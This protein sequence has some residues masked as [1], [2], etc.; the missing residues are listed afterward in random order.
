MRGWCGRL[1]WWGRRGQDSGAKERTN[2]WANSLVFILLVVIHVGFGI[3]FISRLQ[4]HFT[5]VRR[6]THDS[7]VVVLTLPTCATPYAK[8][9]RRFYATR[10]TVC[11]FWKNFDEYFW[12][13]YCFEV[14]PC[15]SPIRFVL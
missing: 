8:R 3:P 12:H 13:F 11:A 4:Q 14:T 1:H 15:V 9:P 2:R 10:K 5:A 7:F 6:R